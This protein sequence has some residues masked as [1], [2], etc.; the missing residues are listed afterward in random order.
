MRGAEAK[1]LSAL[2]DGIAALSPRDDIAVTGVAR[3]AD[4]VRAG[5]LFLAARG[6]AAHGLDFVDEALRRGAAAVAWEPDARRP[7]PAPA[8]V[9]LVR[10]AEL[11]RQAGVVADRFYAHPSARMRVV[12]VTGTNGKTSVCHF[13]AQALA[14]IEGRC[15]VAGTLGHGELGARR[16]GAN[17][18][19]DAVFLHRLLRKLDDDG[20]RSFVMEASS[21]G[22]EQGRLAGLA[23]DVAVLTNLGRDHFDYHGARAQYAAAK[24][25][26]FELPGLKHAVLN[27][28][29]DFARSLLDFCRERC[30][31]TTYGRRAGADFR[32]EIDARGFDGAT[33]RAFT[34]AGEV[35][36]RTRLP[37]EFNALNLNAALA[38][39]GAAGLP[40]QQAAEAL[41]EA[42]GAPGRFERI[43]VGDCDVLIDYAHT[44]DAVAGALSAARA[45]CA[46]RLICMFGC[47]GERD[48]G[49]RPLMGEAA[50]RLADRVVLTDDNPRGEDPAQIIADILAG[51]PAA[52]RARVAVVRDRAQALATAVGEAAAGDCVL[53]LGKGHET[54][55]LVG[56]DARPFNDAEAARALGAARA[57]KQASK[58]ASRQASKQTPKRTPKQT[59][60]QAT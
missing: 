49:K 56:S 38:A 14:R 8:A 27:L 58:Q 15:G 40:P 3:R 23:V 29:D 31:V 51:V 35:C 46:G 32:C 22:L 47:G 2:L 50:A 6:A 17:T 18:T 25:R 1:N 43:E 30:E 57:P 10:V 16:A 55:Q 52:R 28:D 12:A 34:P 11:A 7:A 41:A 37:G 9:P 45:L 39:L 26:L 33:L 60:E 19:P 59:P 44:P 21:H 24:R 13:A 4:E 42:R 54:V 20:V 36:L 48:R 5:D 53:A